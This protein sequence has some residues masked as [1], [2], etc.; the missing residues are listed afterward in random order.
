MVL[1]EFKAM[2]FLER[3]IGIVYDARGLQGFAF[4]LRRG[5]G[6]E[7]DIDG[8]LRCLGVRTVRLTVAL[9][10]VADVRAARIEAGIASAGTGAGRIV[11]RCARFVGVCV[12]ARE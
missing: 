1:V 5:D 3:I 9:I 6:G 8:V 7:F 11:G 12:R 10:I 4:V 2:A